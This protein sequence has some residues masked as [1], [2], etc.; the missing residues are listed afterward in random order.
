MRHQR[1]EAA[2]GGGH[3]RQAA[4]A[5]V[6]VEGVGF[7]RRAVVIHE[8]HGG[9]GLGLVAARAEVGKAFAM[10]DRDG[11]PA[12]RHAGEEQAG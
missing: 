9:D 5:A 1:G 10:R 8:A 7:G 12:A 4:G 6:G 2:V 11:Y 3:R